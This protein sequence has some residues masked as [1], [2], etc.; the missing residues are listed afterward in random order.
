MILSDREVLREVGKAER[1][2][3]CIAA[4]ARQFFQIR[5][6]LCPSVVYFSRA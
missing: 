3:S 4:F 1:Q 6:Y 2:S 5:V